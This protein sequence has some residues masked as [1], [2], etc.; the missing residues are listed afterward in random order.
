[1]AS[2]VSSQYDTC[3]DHFAKFLE[4]KLA[5]GGQGEVLDAVTTWHQ[6]QLLH[7]QGNTT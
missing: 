2:C 5:E 7:E 4:N 6:A 3:Y 1:M